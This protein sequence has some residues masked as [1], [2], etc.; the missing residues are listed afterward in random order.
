V[1]WRWIESLG[2]CLALSACVGLIEDPPSREDDRRDDPA[3]EQA[4]ALAEAPLRRLTRTEYMRCLRD[5]FGDDAVSAVSDALAALPT[6]RQAQ[7]YSTNTSGVS[8]NHVDAYFNVADALASWMV[9][10]PERLGRLDQCLATS[11]DSE[12]ARSVAGRW[13]KR[14][15]RR[16][17]TT[18]EIDGLVA[19]FTDGV[20]LSVPDGV[21]LMLIQLLTAP[22]FVYRVEL[23]EEQVEPNVYELSRWELAT[24][25]SFLV[26]GSTPDDDLLDAAERGALDSNSGVAA[27]LDRL[28]SDPRAREQVAWF[29]DEWLDLDSVPTPQQS[30][31]FLDG[32]PKQS[33]AQDA[34]VEI[35]RLIEEIVF[36][37]RGTYADLLTSRSGYL[38]DSI[39][40]LYSVPASSTTSELPEERAGF[41]TRAAML[42]TN[43]ETTHPIR[44]GVK[45]R[46]R[47]LCENVAPPPPGVANMNAPPFDPSK[48]A[49]ERWTEKTS[50]AP[51]SGCHSRINP[52]GFALENYDSI[53][54][55][56]SFETI[57]DPITHQK[58]NELPIDAAVE[59]MLDGE[60]VSVSGGAALSQAMAASA[61]ARSCFAAQWTAFALGRDVSPETVGDLTKPGDTMLSTLTALTRLPGFRVRKVK[62]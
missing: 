53:G 36:E 5:L 20:S 17:L 12:C 15:Y 31:E 9:S 59:V 8:A 14:I 43:D 46:R 52:F 18:E 40:Q 50:A 56:R 16:P 4:Q 6:D 28:L 48:T 24:R 37:R 44:R 29:F 34:R 1:R 10:S 57:A 41:L 33:L 54:R 42:M 61:Q 51:C 55:F 2:L 26:W 49:R 22:A 60:M 3:A 23:G 47:L 21:Q 32:L 25:L 30:D 27:E 7:R 19:T 58:V 38:S 13:G 39:A 35:A 11:A 45:I 62:P